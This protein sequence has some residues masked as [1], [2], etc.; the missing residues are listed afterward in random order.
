[1]PK[2]LDTGC[3]K[4]HDSWGCF[5][6]GNWN[7][8][9]HQQNEP[10]RSLRLKA[11]TSINEEQL[12][13]NASNWYSDVGEISEVFLLEVLRL[14]TSD[15]F[16]IIKPQSYRLSQNPSKN[17]SVTIFDPKILRSTRDSCGV[18]FCALGSKLC[19]NGARLFSHDGS[20]QGAAA[21]LQHVLQFCCHLLSIA[22]ILNLQQITI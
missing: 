6:L 9:V 7:W 22:S 12:L 15:C 20:V 1:M 14:T 8:K 2:V 17:L 3:E 5:F 18:H 21:W 16:W 10:V 13:N 19:A 11:M 4:C